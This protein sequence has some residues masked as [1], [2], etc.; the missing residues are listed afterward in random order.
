MNIS[1]HN[2]TSIASPT[3]VSG[4]PNAS[5]DPLV[6]STKRSLNDV[7]TALSYQNVTTS[8]SPSA[9]LFAFPGSEVS[10]FGLFGHSNNGYTDTSPPKT[11]TSTTVSPPPGFTS[12]PSNFEIHKQGQQQSSNY[13][14]SL[15]QTPNAFAFS[16]FDIMRTQWKNGSNFK[17]NGTSDNNTTMQANGATY[18]GN[19][20]MNTCAADQTPD[21]LFWFT[22][23]ADTNLA[24]SKN[25]TNVSLSD[26]K[27]TNDSRD[28]FRYYSPGWTHASIG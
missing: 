10:Q 3:P 26:P 19:R 18:Q 9:S 28:Q 7:K 13:Q 4:V 27:A 1:S 17:I 24:S 2:Q 20:D 21:S 14:Q 11:G 8:P 5:Q 16:S 6:P 15:F 23:S 12:D 25:G 22:N